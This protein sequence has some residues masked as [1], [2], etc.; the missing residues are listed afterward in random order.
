MAAASGDDLRCAYP[1]GCGFCGSLKRVEPAENAPLWPQA[2]RWPK[3]GAPE[4]DGS[5]HE[6]VEEGCG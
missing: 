3:K 1:L 2:H 6:T 5:T 4:T